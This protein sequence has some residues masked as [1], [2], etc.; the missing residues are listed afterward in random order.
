M[1]RIFAF[2]NFCYPLNSE[3]A[4]KSSSSN[5]IKQENPKKVESFWR[6]F[7]E[8]QAKEVNPHACGI[9]NKVFA[10]ITSR[11]RHEKIHLGIKPFQC[12]FCFKT[13]SQ[14]GHLGIH[15]RSHT[16]HRPYTCSIC[17]RE[18]SRRDALARHMQI[19]S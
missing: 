6:P 18:F 8:K 11:K 1:F 16:G 5:D 15:L 4:A 13:F 7:E 9:C 14:S 19:H 2:Y 3:K 10:S 12:N 17:N